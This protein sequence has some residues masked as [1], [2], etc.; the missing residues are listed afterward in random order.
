MPVESATARVEK[1]MNRTMIER[2]VEVS[3]RVG[4]LFIATADRNGVP[5]MAS[6]RRA[7]Q[8]AGDRIAVTEWFC[9]G[10]VA[11]LRENPRMSIVVWDSVSDTGYQLIGEAEK[12]EDVAMLDGFEAVRAETPPVPQIERRLI[13]RGRE[14]Y[15][16]RQRPHSDTPVE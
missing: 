11:N 9:P 10:T 12:I 4:F 3:D 13:V 5:H 15:A 6:A 2:M 7:E 8:M 1:I 14:V 16:F